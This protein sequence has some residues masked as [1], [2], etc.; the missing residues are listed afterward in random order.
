M[1][2][3]L[4]FS[5]ALTVL[6][7]AACTEDRFTQTVDIN[8]PE[9]ESRPTLSLDIVGGDTLIWPRIGLSVGI[10]EDD[11][12]SLPANLQ[13]FRDG[14]LLFDLETSTGGFSD[15][16]FNLPAPIPAGPADYEVVVNVAG[17]GSARAGQRMPA[18]PTVELIRYER[19]GAIDIDGF[20]VSE[21]VVRINDPADTENYYAFRIVDPQTSCSPDTCFAIYRE[22]YSRYI[23][24]PD[25]LLRQGGYHGAVVSD[26]SFNGESYDMRLQFDIYGDE[27]ALE[28]WSITEDGF[29]YIVSLETYYNADGN[30]FAEPVN[31][32]DNI[33]EGYGIFMASNRL[34]FVL[35]E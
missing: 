24:S 1:K 27:K 35:E 12:P 17:F 10:L 14:E 11:P 31:V 23:S 34:R 4:I 19:E 15:S 3:L 21:A 25:P 8:L 33:E 6:L 22:S 16:G 7:T 18:A 26:R 13:L 30:P 5:A 29:R 20:R 28:V 9:H 32:H 2:Q